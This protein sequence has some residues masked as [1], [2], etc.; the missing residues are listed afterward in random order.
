MVVTASEIDFNNLGFA[1]MNL[2]YR[3]LSTYKD[4][5]WDNGG[6]VEGNQLAIPE[7]SP[8]LHYG[9]QCFEGLKVGYLESNKTLF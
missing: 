1:Y 3:Y 5:Q 4:G 7:G 9:Q 2:P 6:L 8:A